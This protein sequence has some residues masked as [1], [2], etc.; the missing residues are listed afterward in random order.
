MTCS[1]GEFK[2]SL[3]DWSTTLSLEITK[4]R[5]SEELYKTNLYRSKSQKAKRLCTGTLP[6]EVEISAVLTLEF[7]SP[8]HLPLYKASARHQLSCLPSQNM[9]GI[10][11]FSQWTIVIM[12]SHIL[13]STFTKYL[14]IPCTGLK[15]NDDSKVTLLTN[16]SAF[17]IITCELSYYNQY[18]TWAF[19]NIHMQ[20]KMWIAIKNIEKLLSASQW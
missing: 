15:E 10:D 12:Q 17:Y 2:G 13:Y 11:M 20:S 9:P 7:L 8:T 4:M 16:L 1:W 3:G 18:Y 5:S 14:S 6:P 19:T